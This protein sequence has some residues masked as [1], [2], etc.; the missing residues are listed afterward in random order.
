MRDGINQKTVAK[1]RKRTSVADL[2]TE[3]RD[4]K[5]TVLTPKI[6]L[7]RPLSNLTVVQ[8]SGPST[9]ERELSAGLCTSLLSRRIQARC[10]NLPA[11][12]VLTTRELKASHRRSHRPA[13]QNA[14]TPVLV[15]G[16]DGPGLSRLA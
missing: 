9:G 3:P 2:P 1:W 13:R 12:A 10:V 11:P 4:A 14:T 7:N 5:S 15:G 6:T 8:V 16:G